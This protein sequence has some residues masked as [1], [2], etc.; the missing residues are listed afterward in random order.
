MGVV[1][2]R[3][4]VLMSSYNGEQYIAQQIVSIMEQQ[5]Q[6]ELVLRIRD[7]GSQ[8]ATCAVIEGLQKKY[9]GRIE[10]IRGNNI[11]YNASFF[12]LLGN[13]QGYDFYAISDQ[14][15]VWLPDKIQTAVEALMRTGEGPALYAST[16]T[17]VDEDLNVI[18]QTRGQKR[19]FSFYNTIVQ[20]ICPGHTQVMNGAMLSLL[21]PPPDASRVYVY[22][23]WI[24]NMAILYGKLV[25]DAVPHTL[26]R[27][28]RKNQLG[29]GS[30]N[31]GQLNSS[32]KHAFHG[33]GQKYRAQI[34]YFVEK[35]R[36]RLSEEN[37]L[38]ELE[39]F[40]AAT[41]FPTRLRYAIKSKLFR[42]SL[43]ETAA[44][45]VAVIIGFF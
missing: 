43:I 39:A 19:P 1:R 16:S 41:D 7:D 37:K 14:D 30:G 15:D 34:A 40:L 13:A 11:G 26:Y 36:E 5:T 10:L 24:S 2:K 17:L 33:D 38:A 22:D 27:Q 4:L 8:D 20:N 42:Q 31:L 45:R 28:H 32:V 29:S 9:P 21:Q 12:D 6:Y 3:I 25:F 35:N 44:F 23:S 18:G